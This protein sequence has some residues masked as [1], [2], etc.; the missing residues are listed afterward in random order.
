MS[1]Y[2]NDLLLK[3]DLNFCQVYSSCDAAIALKSDVW[4]QTIRRSS[5]PSAPNVNHAGLFLECQLWLETYSI[6]KYFS[7]VSSND[8]V[9]LQYGEVLREGH[10]S[11]AVG[12]FHDMTTLLKSSQQKSG[13]S[14]YQVPS[15]SLSAPRDIDIFPYPDKFGFYQSDYS[16]ETEFT[17]FR[18]LHTFCFSNVPTHP[19]QILWGARLSLPK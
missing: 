18:R 9:E 17:A 13:C 19:A 1:Y 2:W 4:L 6:C 3:T 8:R 7:S 11:L 5:A 10:P 16:R 14:L 15:F 12:D